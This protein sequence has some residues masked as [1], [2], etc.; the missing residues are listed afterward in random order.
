MASDDWLYSEPKRKEWECLP[1]RPRKK[2]VL[3]VR[4][5]L[6]RYGIRPLSIEHRAWQEAWEWAHRIAISYVYTRWPDARE[7]A[8]QY[9]VLLLCE[10]REDCSLRLP[11]RAGLRMT[12]VVRARLGAHMP[13]GLPAP[14]EVA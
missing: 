13:L 6:R 12:D 3:E 10:M 5:H 14:E 11:F 9:L 8:T 7:I 2:L 1:G 4:R